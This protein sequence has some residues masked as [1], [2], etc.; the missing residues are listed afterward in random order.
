MSN[1]HVV[2]HTVKLR[3]LPRLE[4]NAGF[5]RFLMKGIK[6]D[7]LIG[8]SRQ[9]S[10]F[11]LASKVFTLYQI[12]MVD[13]VLQESLLSLLSQIQSW[14]SFMNLENIWKQ[15]YIFF[16]LYS[17]KKWDVPSWPTYQPT[18]SL[19]SPSMLNLPTYPK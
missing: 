19:F 12:Q 3:V 15:D 9:I 13:T 17:A 6:N 16:I 4:T 1:D 18:M 7:F 5:F 11:L 8:N 14:K 2:W 10:C